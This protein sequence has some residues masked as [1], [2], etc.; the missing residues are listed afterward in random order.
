MTTNITDIIYE[1][2][3]SRREI[4]DKKNAQLAYY[5]NAA[6]AFSIIK[7]KEIWMR[8][9]RCMNDW[10]EVQ[11]GRDLLISTLRNEYFS[12]LLNNCL[13]KFNP[14]LSSTLNEIILRQIN[15]IF[16]Q[17]YLTCLT[18]HHPGKYEDKI[19]R[20]SMWRAYG[21]NSPVA[22]VICKDKAISD[23]IDVE[24]EIF[25]VEYTT[26]EQFKS[27][28]YNDITRIGDQAEPIA[29]E[30]CKYVADQIFKILFFYMICSK[31]PGFHE[32]KEWRLTANRHVWQLNE[33]TKETPSGVEVIDGTPQR[34]FKFS[35]DNI[36]QSDGANLRL[37]EIISHILIGPSEN[38][39]IVASALEA[40]L[41]RAGFSNPQDRIVVSG[42]PL[43]T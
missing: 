37:D 8:N 14:H 11:Y 43:R 20:L 16:E 19:G 27:N 12:T 28:L 36:L 6:T 10:S 42:I 29:D 3:K 31:H 7:N 32:E 9:A 5:T 39:R 34:V 15:N 22:L 33:G 38:P 18:E 1:R 23:D 13:S 26:S 2:I 24:P 41:A 21:G 25:P 35:I 30:N 4:L 40:E 17:T